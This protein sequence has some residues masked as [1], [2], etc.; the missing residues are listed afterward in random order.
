MCLK[1]IG[2]KERIEADFRPSRPF[3]GWLG[4]NHI[5]G[6]PPGRLGLAVLAATLAF[7]ANA[8][9]PTAPVPVRTTLVGI[10]RLAS[11]PITISVRL[12]NLTGKAVPLNIGFPPDFNVVITDSGGRVVKRRLPPPTPGAGSL[13]E[14]GIVLDAYEKQRFA[15][16]W[17]LTDDQG[18]TVP[19]GRYCLKGEFHLT[20][21]PVDGLDS[22]PFCLWIVHT[23]K[24]LTTG[25][26]REAH[27]NLEAPHHR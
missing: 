24:G 26:G 20:G 21:P 22:P 17:D 12:E 15:W 25:A 5:Q 7:E 4:R 9:T 1:D 13:A 11:R 3:S 2:P 14:R 19:N 6:I 27:A 16:A 8:G 23:G 10:P 18:K